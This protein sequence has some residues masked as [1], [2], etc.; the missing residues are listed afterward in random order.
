MPPEGALTYGLINSAKQVQA[1]GGGFGDAKTNRLVEEAAIEKVCRLLEQR[2]FRVRSRESERIGYDLD[3]A[4]GRTELHV[5]VKGVSGNGMQFLIT[6]AEV[7][8][9]ASD[10]AFRLMVVTEARTRRARVQ[11]FHGRDLERRFALTP[12]SYIASQK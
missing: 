10:S 5:E 4:K 3:A 6:Q 1:A 7:A 9:A 2:G 8:K 11:E 12:V